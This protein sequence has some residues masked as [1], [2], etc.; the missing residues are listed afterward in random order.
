MPWWKSV[1]RRSL[2]ALSSAL[3]IGVTGCSS[4]GRGQPPTT[5]RGSTTSAIA[6]SSS[7]SAPALEDDEQLEPGTRY[8]APP[9]FQPAFTFT[10]PSN[11][12]YPYLRGGSAMN[13]REASSVSDE[14]AQTGI[15]IVGDSSTLTEAVHS[16]LSS[17]ALRAGSQHR[18]EIGGRPALWFDVTIRRSATL[19]EPA[20]LDGQQV[21]PGQGLRVYATSGAG[22]SVLFLAFAP[23]T[24]LA[25]FVAD[26][27]ALVSS[28]RL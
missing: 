6:P 2:V 7:S 12:W 3:A 28:V 16:L 18:L 11:H 8:A 22:G 5:P 19:H 20:S 17:D 25:A 10:V 27:Q 1:D 26:A 9:D 15:E 14:S 13:L 23:K 4:S 24:R 21:D